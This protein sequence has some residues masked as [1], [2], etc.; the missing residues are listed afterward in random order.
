[1]DAQHRPDAARQRWQEARQLLG[2]VALLP[3]H[4]STFDAA[5]RQLEHL[6]LDPVSIERTLWRYWALDRKDRAS[7]RR[8][9]LG[10]AAMKKRALARRNLIAAT[11]AALAFYREFFK[12]KD[13][14]PSPI[15]LLCRTLH[16]ALKKSYAEDVVI[17]A[18][19]DPIRASR[20]AALLPDPL[21]NDAVWSEKRRRQ[22]RRGRRLKPHRKVAMKE[23]RAA[24]VPARLI[25]VLLRSVAA[26]SAS[27]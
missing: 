15:Y 19:A 20:V 1:M 26:P 5:L 24:K 6:G 4:R 18:L 9:N 25:P 27:K 14:V 13:P 3:A 22:P 7:Q 2:R 11:G 8:K 23:L 10:I 16:A 12:G 21:Y 17:K